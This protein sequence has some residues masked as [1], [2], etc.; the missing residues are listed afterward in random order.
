MRR[1]TVNVCPHADRPHVRELCGDAPTLLALSVIRYIASA[2]MTAD[3]ACWDAAFAAAEDALGPVEGP[4][5]VG[6]MAGLTRALRVERQGDWHFLPATCCRA[7]DDEADLIRAL[8]AAGGDGERACVELART[9]R[10]PRIRDSLRDVAACLHQA[11]GSLAHPP[12][13]RPIH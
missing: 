11:A 12:E 6:V 1:S 10:C 4:Q 9:P 3:A 8:R 2:A 13:A 5:F 7:T